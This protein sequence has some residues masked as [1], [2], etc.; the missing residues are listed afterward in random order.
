[1]V[2]HVK[3]VVA[4]LVKEKDGKKRYITNK[5]NQPEDAFYNGQ[6]RNAKRFTGLEQI[7]IDWEDH[8]IEKEV[9]TTTTTYTTYSFSELREVNDE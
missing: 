2:S 6:R 4:Y 7:N 3:E 1:M 9:V 8:L 5:P